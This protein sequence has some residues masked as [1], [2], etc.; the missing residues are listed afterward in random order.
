MSTS[1]RAARIRHIRK[2]IC[3]MRV[4]RDNVDSQCHTSA[5]YISANFKTCVKHIWIVM[6]ITWNFSYNST[7]LR[8]DTVATC[9][10]GVK[11]PVLVHKCPVSC[12]ALPAWCAGTFFAG[13]RIQSYPWINLNYGAW[14]C[15]L[16]IALNFLTVIL[17]S[18]LPEQL[19]DGAMERLYIPKASK[20]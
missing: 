18:S 9:Q 10:G 8:I 3:Y 20:L 19:L 1:L 11:S 12:K 14:W 2:R 6:L 7:E 13:V 15:Q 17:P 16:Y 4:P 5:K